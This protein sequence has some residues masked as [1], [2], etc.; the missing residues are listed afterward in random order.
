MQDTIILKECDRKFKYEVA[1]QPGGEH[2]KV[3]FACG[4]CTA[5]CPVSSVDE[6]YSPREIIRMI[7]LGMKKEVLS[8][9]LIWRCQMCYTCF[10]TCPQDVRFATV[11]RA[12]RNMAIIEGHVHPSFLKRMDELD[13][14]AQKMRLDMVAKIVSERDKEFKD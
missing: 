9:S 10:A 11:I 4:V 13:R 2:I 1:E 6:E 3:C 12:L 8:S 5:G 14:N 7:M